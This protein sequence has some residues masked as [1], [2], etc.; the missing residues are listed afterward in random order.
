MYDGVILVGCLYSWLTR[1]SRN[2]YFHPRKLMPMVIWL[3]E[4]T[5]M[6]VVTNIVAGRS[7]LPRSNS[8]HCHPVDS[9]F[10]INILLSHAICSSLRWYGLVTKKIT[11]KIECVYRLHHRLCS[12]P[13]LDWLLSRKLKP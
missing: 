7:T 12:V 11:S 3:H 13:P 10:D 1:Q 4:S 9:I 2:T 6:G 8:S 5:M